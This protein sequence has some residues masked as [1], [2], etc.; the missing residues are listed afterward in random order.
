MKPDIKLTGG[1]IVEEALIRVHLQSM[2]WW[3]RLQAGLGK[4]DA[5]G[6]GKGDR[7]KALEAL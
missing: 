1:T 3:R 4:T 7:G 2:E 5:T 6:M